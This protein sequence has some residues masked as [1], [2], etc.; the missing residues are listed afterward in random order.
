M[1]MNHTPEEWAKVKA[2][3]VMDG[4]RAQRINV[5]HM[6]L[7]DIA[8]MA[9]E[10]ATLKKPPTSKSQATADAVWLAQVMQRVLAAYG[11]QSDHIGDSDLDNEQPKSLRVGLL[12]GDIRRARGYV[13]RHGMR[14]ADLA[15]PK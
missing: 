1:F 3:A 5:L 13:Q 7:D 8:R 14:P 15:V 4:S 6:A 9:A 11:S 10:I 12:L 2:E